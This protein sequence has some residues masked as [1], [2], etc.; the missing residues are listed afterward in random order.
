MKSAISFVVDI[1]MSEI[2][3]FIAIAL[4]IVSIIGTAMLAVNKLERYQ[5]DSYEDMTGKETIYAEWDSCYINVN[6]E[7]FNKHQYISILNAR[8]GLRSAK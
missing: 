7:W 6:G 4:I 8:E 5:C 2:G 1:I 3:A